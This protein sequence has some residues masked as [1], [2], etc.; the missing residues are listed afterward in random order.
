MT[1]ADEF[2]KSAEL[3]RKRQLHR[4]IHRAWNEGFW[5]GFIIAVLACATIEIFLRTL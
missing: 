2:R 4:R 5:T 1:E 3:S